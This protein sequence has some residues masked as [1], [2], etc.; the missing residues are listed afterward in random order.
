MPFNTPSLS[1]SLIV[2][3]PDDPAPVIPTTESNPESSSIRPSTVVTESKLHQHQ[4][5]QQ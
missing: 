1:S 4:F 5:E 3:D 2:T